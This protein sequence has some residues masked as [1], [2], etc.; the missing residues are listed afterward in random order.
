MR[1]RLLP[2]LILLSADPAFAADCT[3]ETRDMD[4]GI[5]DPTSSQ[6]SETSGSI[7]LRCT[8]GSELCGDLHYSLAISGGDAAAPDRAMA[9][10]GPGG[11]GLRFELYLDPARSIPWGSGDRAISGTFRPGLFGETMQIM[12]YGRIP[13]LQR[14]APGHY[15]DVGQVVMT[16]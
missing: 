6:P 10:D 14:V 1:L 11:G 8:C 4:F 13:P 12:I 2:G 5:Y 16:F 7:A 3:V 15:S 9:H